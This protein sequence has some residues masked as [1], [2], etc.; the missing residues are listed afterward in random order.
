MKEELKMQIIRLRID[1][2]GYKKIAT[3]LNI[4]VERVKYTCKRYG[5]NGLAKNIKEKY[6]NELTDTKDLCKYCNKIFEQPKRGR[7][8]EYCSVECKRKWEK[9]HYKT[10][11][12]K[13]NYCGKMF[14]SPSKRQKFCSKK[15]YYK[16]RFYRDEDIAA[17][18]ECLKKGES[19][20]FIP[21][22]IRDLICGDIQ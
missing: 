1:G 20:E 8:R 14:E 4:P 5:Y 18:A 9:T 2:L 21:S 6:Q 10:H 7:R 12:H 16:Y 11:Q 17:L 13:C 3:A 19:P 22:W 15:C